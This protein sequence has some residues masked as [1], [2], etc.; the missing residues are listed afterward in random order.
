MIKKINP[1]KNIKISLNVKGKKTEDPPA[2][3]KVIKSKQVIRN[4]GLTLG[5][6]KKKINKI[7]QK[8][9][10]RPDLCFGKHH[11]LL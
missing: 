9:S 7:G 5:K 4:R 3:K 11:K 10:V 1:K 8:I 2:L 6:L